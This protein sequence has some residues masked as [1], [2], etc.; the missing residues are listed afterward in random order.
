MGFQ[1]FIVCTSG[2][3]PDHVILL[4]PVPHLLQRKQHELFGLGHLHEVLK[5]ILVSR[6]EQVTAGVRV[7]EATDAQAVG[8]VQLAE[9]EL[10][11]GVTDA[12]QLQEAGSGKQRLQ[13]DGQGGTEMYISDW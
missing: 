11:A 10:A 1:Y 2:L 7:G 9:Q 5:H 12:V 6:L 8:G 13:G 3:E 4:S